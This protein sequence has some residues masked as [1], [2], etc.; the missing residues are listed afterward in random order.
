VTGPNGSGKSTLLEI[1]AGIKRPT[2]GKIIFE[3]DND[4]IGISGIADNIGFSSLRINPYQDLTAIENIEFVYKVYNIQEY[5]NYIKS[6]FNKFNLYNERNKRIRYFSSGMMQRLRFILAVL[7]DP[8]ILILDEPGSNLDVN[9]KEAIYSYIESVKEKK[10]VII[11]TNEEEEA[12]LCDDR[13]Y[14]EN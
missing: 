2:A 12:C 6:L 9:G 10:L 7:N 8:H 3:K 5:K 14:L 13:V 4:E 1:I 11:A